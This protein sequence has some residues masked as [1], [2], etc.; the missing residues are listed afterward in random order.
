MTT[1]EPSVMLVAKR[2]SAK[3]WRSARHD[4]D[5]L[6]NVSNLK[7]HLIS[8]PHFCFLWQVCKR[9]PLGFDGLGLLP[10]SCLRTFS[11]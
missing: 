10:R 7:M 2:C 11:H 9:I 6:R 8:L 1:E 3:T 4:D 5:G